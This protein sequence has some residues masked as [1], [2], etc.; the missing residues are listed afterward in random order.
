[1]R[2]IEAQELTAFIWPEFVRYEGGLYLAR[3]LPAPRPVLRAAPARGERDE[4]LPNLTQAEAMYN[5][6]HVLD[7]FEHGAALDG[8]DPERG[9]R[10][11]FHPEFLAACE[12]GKQVA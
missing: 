2:V 5:H 8:S 12:L 11:R 3:G 4:G 6:V 10:D 1:M 9:F 7:R